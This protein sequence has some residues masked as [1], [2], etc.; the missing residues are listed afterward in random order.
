MSSTVTL[1]WPPSA[2]AR[3]TSARAASSRSSLRARSP[4][5][6]AERESCRPSVHRSRR[7]R[8]GNPVLQHL[9]RELAHRADRL[10]EDVLVRM[11]VRVLGAEQPVLHHR[12]DQRVVVGELLHGLARDR[13]DARVADVRDHRAALAH[14]HRG[15]RGAHAEGAALVGL[16]NDRGVGVVAR[17]QQELAAVAQ[18]RRAR[19]RADRGERGIDRDPAGDLARRV[20]A[21]AVRHDEEPELQVDRR[22]V[23][24][25]RAFDAHVGEQRVAHQRGPSGRTRASPCRKLYWMWSR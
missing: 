21:H 7:P 13:V 12:R 15:Q 25:V 11:G 14:E 4:I 23:L 20:A 5:S 8:F 2:F 19:A 16:A 1:S 24:V 10:G 3:S 22:A 18:P 6:A 9:R 17:L